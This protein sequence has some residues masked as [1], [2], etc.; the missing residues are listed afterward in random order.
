MTPDVTKR[1][2]GPSTFIVNSADY[3]YTEYE[4]NNQYDNNYA[5]QTEHE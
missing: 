3:H 1:P 4:E 5:D 2:E